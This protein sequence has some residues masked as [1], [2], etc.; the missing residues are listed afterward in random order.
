MQVVHRVR[1]PVQVQ[2][3][4][5]HGIKVFKCREVFNSLELSNK[6]ARSLNW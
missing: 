2:P 5:M 4:W 3:L 6:P 1:Q